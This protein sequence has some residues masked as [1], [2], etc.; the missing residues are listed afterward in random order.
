VG[1]HVAA[2]KI[3]AFALSGCLAA[4]GGSLSVLVQPYPYIDPRSFTI[5]LSISL[6]TGLVVGGAGSVIGAIVAALFLDRVPQVTTDIAQ[7]NGVATNFFYGGLLIVLMFVMPT[8]AVGF[9]SRISTRI[10]SSA[11]LCR[12]RPDC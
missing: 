4:V 5:A 12:S 3:G 11:L 1:V 6:V 2:Y 8:G 7:L 10:R 9:A